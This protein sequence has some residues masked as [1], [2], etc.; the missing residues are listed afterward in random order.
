MCLREQVQ[1]STRSSDRPSAAEDLEAVAAPHV[2]AVQAV[3]VEPHQPGP[4]CIRA[5]AVAGEVVVRLAGRVVAVDPA[6]VLRA[7]AGP[8]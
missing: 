3:A 8:I 7:G 1:L 4:A 2:G 6:Q 5:V